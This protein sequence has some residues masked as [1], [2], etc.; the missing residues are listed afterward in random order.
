MIT[1]RQ[2]RPTLRL[3][4]VWLLCLVPVWTQ[5]QE[6]P[7]ESFRYRVDVQ[8]VLVST[9]VLDAEGHP[10]TTLE[11][12]AFT[13]YENGQMRPLRL[14]ERKTAQPL[15]LVLMVDASLSVASELAAQKVA[16]GRF[17][18]RVLQPKDTAALYE[19]SGEAKP[20][21]DFT[22][23][24]S[25]L[26]AGLQ[27]IRVRAGTA[28]YDA[29]EAAAEKLKEREGRRVLVVISDGGDTTSKSDFKG[30]LRAAQE[31]ETTLFALV[32]RPIPGE[33]GRN[34]RGENVLTTLADLTGGLVFFTDRVG[35]LDGFFDDL[36][37]LLRTQYLLG[38]QAAPPSFRPEFRTIEVRLKDP[39]YRVRHRQGYYSEPRQ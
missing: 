13:V 1:F 12:E 23:S 28:L 36:N 16:I 26:Q 30:A 34:V 22:E 31:A 39:G 7:P 21:V 33:S 8:L 4:W 38:Y 32:V 2:H 25:Q 11:Q 27:G 18:Q 29:I 6:P 19:L 17:I 37:H 20:V 35:E 15:Q 24:A 5:A 10:V 9:S 3:F 14:F